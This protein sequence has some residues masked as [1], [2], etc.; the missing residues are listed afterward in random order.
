MFD[1]SSI[2][3]LCG[4]GLELIREGGHGELLLLLSFLELS[5]DAVG[6]IFLRIR[7]GRATLTRSHVEKE[8]RRRW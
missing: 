1:R 6:H 7:S 8:S 5:C 2:Y 3:T 4:C